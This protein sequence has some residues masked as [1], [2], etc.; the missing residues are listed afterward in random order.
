MA[1]LGGLETA[2]KIAVKN[3]CPDSDFGG[4]L[5][6]LIATLYKIQNII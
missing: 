5:E 3:I 6:S 4:I 2:P 1:M